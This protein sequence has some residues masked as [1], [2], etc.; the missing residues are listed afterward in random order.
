MAMPE[1][2]RGTLGNI[3]REVLFLILFVVCSATLFIESNLPNRVSESTAD[4]YKSLMHL[5]PAKAVFVQSDWTNSTRGESRAQFEGMIRILIRKRIKIG[6]LSVGDPQAPEVARGAIEKIAREEEAKGGQPYKRWEDWVFVGF[7]PGAEASMQSIGTNL[8]N[9]T[10]T[11]KDN[12]SN[13]VKR[14][15]KE[16]PV[17]N[18]IN[19]VSDLG[20]YIVVTGTK[21]SR[22]SI[23]RLSGRVTMLA[24][25]TGVMGPETFNYYQ[26]K[27]LAG[28]GI[29]LKGAYDLE[30]MMEYGLNTTGADGKV[31]V[32]NSKVTDVVDGWAGKQ[33]LANAQKYIVPL[34]GAIFLL[35]LAIVL[36]NIQTIR[37]RKKKVNA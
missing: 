32:S 36:G 2:T 10:S 11:K 8:S 35:I 4:L 3:P 28:L 34:H 15:I 17:M 26:T 30:S 12:D 7:F 19:T 6:L 24:Q 9:A 29:G 22:I 13:G 16:S 1:K 5:D 25:V 18:G 31:K 27:Q 37:D 21:S 33:N 20:A 14:S 23:E